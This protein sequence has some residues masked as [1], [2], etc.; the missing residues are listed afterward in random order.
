MQ[1]LCRLTTVRSSSVYLDQYLSTGSF[2]DR[3]FGEFSFLGCCAQRESLSII[4]ISSSSG[5]GWMVGS[6]SLSTSTR[7]L[8]SGP[9]TW[10]E[11]VLTSTIVPVEQKRLGQHKMLNNSGSSVD[12]L[13]YRWKSLAK[14]CHASACSWTGGVW[15]RI[16]WCDYSNRRKRD[17]NISFVY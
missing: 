5:E 6:L 13:D 10:F 4:L 17:V 16:L 11:V 12:R 8:V 3:L 2:T 1:W 15:T 14:S 7:G 9:W